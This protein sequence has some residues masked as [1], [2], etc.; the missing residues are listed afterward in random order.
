MISRDY[1]YGWGRVDARAALDMV[2]AHRCDLNNDWKVD[3]QDLVLLNEYI[4]A[5]DLSGDIAPAAKR[6]GG[7]DVN[8]IELLM[9][10]MGIEIPEIGSLARWKLDEVNGVTAYDCINRRDGTL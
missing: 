4:D 7:V 10:Y 1:Y 8:D 3:E 9:Q 2:L 5:N 6:D